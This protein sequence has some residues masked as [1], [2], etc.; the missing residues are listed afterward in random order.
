[1]SYWM[2][3]KSSVLEQRWLY[4][5][6]EALPTRVKRKSLLPQL[7]IHLIQSIFF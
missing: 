5:L 7:F 4:H 3:M 6:L 2:L 1:M